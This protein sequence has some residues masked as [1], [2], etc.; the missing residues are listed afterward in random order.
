[1]AVEV[2]QIKISAIDQF[3]GTFA[4]LGRAA[5]SINSSMSGLTNT[6]GLLGGISIGAGI[7]SAASSFLALDK[8][9]AAASAKFGVLDRDSEKFKRLREEVLQLG[10][11]TEFTSAQV[12]EGFNNMGAAGFN[13][14]QSLSGMAT[15]LDLATASQSDLAESAL[16]AGKTLGAFGL[17]SDDPKI[18]AENLGMV[19]NVLNKLKSGKEF[20]TLDEIRTAITASGQTL[21]TAG[22]DINTWGAAIG[23]IIGP[24]GDASVAGTGLAGVIDKLGKKTKESEKLFDN[25]GIKVADETTGDFKDLF[26]IV[27]ELNKALAGKGSAQKTEIL[28]TMFDSRPAKILGALMDVGQE[29]LEAYR[30]ELIN[31]NTV[32]K[33]MAKFMR[34][35]LTGAVAAMSSAF[36]S[37]GTAL[38]DV[39]QPEIDRGIEKLTGLAL[40]ARDWIKDNKEMI[41]GIVKITGQ[42]I[43]FVLGLKA[44]LVVMSAVNAVI[45]M[46]PIMLMVTAIVLATGALYLMVKN[47]TEAKKAI[48]G[49]FAS[50]GK[51]RPL[52][53]FFEGIWEYSKGLIEVFS[54][55]SEGGFIEGIKQIGKSILSLILWPLEAIGGI[56]ESFGFEQKELNDLKSFREGLSQQKSPF[57]DTATAPAVSTQAT[58]AEVTNQQNIASKEESV[59]RLIADGVQAIKEKGTMKG[60]SIEQLSTTATF[61]GR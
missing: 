19:A 2:T 23:S 59:V 44:L 34:S 7:A 52:L 42:M 51:F 13:L 18:M 49:F 14:E 38:G 61:Q 47:W 15:V 3:S 4:K 36:D 57:E 54:A 40:G 60:V 20:Q 21:K 41:L 53:M 37:V 32:T 43:P 11:T 8:N 33:D 25:L 30:D 10:A 24:I 35:G 56:L 39:F 1:M 46:N 29:K 17:K 22:A 27:G 58:A 31:A 55:F 9:M 28:S 45:M 26:V 48:D 6:I 50:T 12:A 16:I 5:N